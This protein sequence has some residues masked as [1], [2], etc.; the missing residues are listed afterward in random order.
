[1]NGDT[2]WADREEEDIERRFAAG[3]ISREQAAK[4]H[5]AL[6]YEIRAQYDQEMDDAQRRVNEEW[7]GA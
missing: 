6:R 5:A 7:G 3:E 1:M 2:R 4:E